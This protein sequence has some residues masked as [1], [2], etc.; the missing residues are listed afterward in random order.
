M[1]N[2]AR[3]EQERSILRAW[4][5]T[6]RRYRQWKRLSRRELA[7][8]AGISP[9]FLGEIERG[10]KD[11]SSHSLCL[12]AEALNVPLSELYL[13]VATRLDSTARTDDRTGQRALP[14]RVRENGDD[15]LE[16]V[17]LASDETAFDLYKV[18]RLLRTD[19]QVSLLVLAR[20]LTDERD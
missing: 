12:V 8:L 1:V 11:P 15:Y 17:S 5:E 4:G 16:G 10:E 14:L 13:R 9:V 2:G 7:Q 19:Q 6:I 18:V 3:G 20:S